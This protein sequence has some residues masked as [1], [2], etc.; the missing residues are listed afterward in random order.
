MFNTQSSDPG[1]D[2]WTSDSIAVSLITLTNDETARNAVQFFP[3]QERRIF[4]LKGSLL[5]C[6]VNALLTREWTVLKFTGSQLDDWVTI[7]KGPKAVDSAHM[8]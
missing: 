4:F 6:H 8:Y 7:S 2:Q 1:Y 5:Q 3:N